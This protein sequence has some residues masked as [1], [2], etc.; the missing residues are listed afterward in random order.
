MPYRL[1]NSHG[2]LCSANTGP[3][4]TI[5]PVGPYMKLPVHMSLYLFCGSPA[6]MLQLLCNF[7]TI[8]GLDVLK[9]T[10]LKDQF[11]KP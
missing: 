8:F 5:R 7:I 1:G 2:G 9:Q 10:L 3:T 4:G 6:H 11:L